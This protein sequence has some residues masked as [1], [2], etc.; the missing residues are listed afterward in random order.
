MFNGTD[1]DRGELAVCCLK[2]AQLALRLMNLLSKNCPEVKIFFELSSTPAQTIAA[3]P[4]ASVT[5]TVATGPPMLPTSNCLL[6]F[7]CD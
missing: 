6:Q 1:A 5:S 4:A 7:W 2:D 3:I